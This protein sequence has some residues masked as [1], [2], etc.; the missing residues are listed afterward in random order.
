M[1]MEMRGDWKCVL[2]VPGELC[3]VMNLMSVKQLLPVRHWEGSEE[4]VSS[5]L[6]QAS[7]Y[8]VMLSLQLSSA[9]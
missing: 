8:E 6:S 7:L 1:M 5:L 3:A 2:I 4:M 9:H